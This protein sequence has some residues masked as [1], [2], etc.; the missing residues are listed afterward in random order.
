[1]AFHAT[2]ISILTPLPNLLLVIP[3]VVYGAVTGWFLGRYWTPQ[4]VSTQ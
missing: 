2:H 3:H 1:M 4:R